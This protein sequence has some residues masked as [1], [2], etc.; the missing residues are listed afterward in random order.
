M[1]DLVVIIIILNYYFRGPW[2]HVLKMSFNSLVSYAA[3]VNEK[4]R[5]YL[6]LYLYL[7]LYMYSTGNGISINN[8]HFAPIVAIHK[9]FVSHHTGDADLRPQ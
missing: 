3:A 4:K 6:Y 9:F 7:C 8:S 2:E 1:V 5:L